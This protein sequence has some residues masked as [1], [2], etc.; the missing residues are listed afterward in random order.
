MIKILRISGFVLTFLLLSVNCFASSFKGDEINVILEELKN[1]KAT[2]NYLHLDVVIYSNIKGTNF[3]VSQE[4]FEADDVKKKT[5]V[6]LEHCV[7]YDKSNSSIMTHVMW[8]PGKEFRCDYNALGGSSVKLVAVK[9]G[10]REYDP[11]QVDGKGIYKVTEVNE[12]V[13]WE[14][15]STKQVKLKYSELKL[16]NL[17]W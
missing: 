14:L 9:S 15:R 16:Q 12:G 3:G 6:S 7:S 1:G 2:G 11:W 10:A 8:I 5:T 4:W 17:F 13:K